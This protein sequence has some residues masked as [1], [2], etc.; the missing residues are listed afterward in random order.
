[1]R[2]K[3]EIIKEY[4]RWIS[5]EAENSDLYVELIGMND[6][7]KEDAFFRN[8]EFGTGGLRGIMGAGTNR[9]NV[10]TVAKAS[11]G[12][13]DYV[14]EHSGANPSIAIAYDSRINSELFSKTAA[15]VFAA[16]NIHTFI[17]SEIM[18]TPCLSYAVRKLKCSAGIVI[19]ASH[20][21]SM[22]NGYKV[23]GPDGCQIT[24]EAAEVILS[25]IEFLD[26][27]SDVNHKDFEEALKCGSIEYI[28]DSIIDE[29]VGEIKGQ[30]VLFGD[31]IDRDVAIVYSPLNGTGLKLVTRALSEAGFSNI[32]VVKEQEKPDGR[33]TT[34]PFPNPENR[35]AMEMGVEYCKKINAD[36]L[37]A[38]DPD[39]DRC[40]IAVKNGEEYRLMTGNEIGLL[41]LDYIC[42]QRNKHGKMPALPVFVKTIVTTDLSERIAAQYSV[43]TINVLTGFKYIGEVI[44]TLETEGRADDYICGFEESYGYLTGTYVRDKDA[45]NAALMICEMYAFYRTRG[46]SLLDKLAEIYNNHGYSKNSLQSY[47]FEGS[48][49]MR[50]MHDIMEKLRYGIYE[51]AGIKVVD[52]LDYNNGIAGLPASDVIKFLLEDGSSVVIRPS[53]TEPKLKTY[54]SV[55]AETIEEAENKE[56]VIIESLEGELI[57]N[58]K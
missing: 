24:N 16:N 44:G 52:M 48:S 37:L 3:E 7:D 17:F 11:Q 56:R 2:S 57:D 8:L 15:S 42:C 31:E 43:E 54:I 47:S 27:F 33:F 46:I 12:L 39:A 35:E 53:G 5:R 13:A 55:V 4:D 22:Y 34:C 38:T 10:R 30:S 21:P 9:M 28:C 26:I 40:G 1:M 36:L 41:M 29:Y 32:T 20:N 19:T 14:L 58:G 45:V 51:I 23:Y 50:I 6:A 49:G 18:P 25:K